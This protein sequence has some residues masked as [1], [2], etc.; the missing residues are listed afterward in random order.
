MRTRAEL[1]AGASV[2]TAAITFPANTAGKW[3]LSNGLTIIVQEDR[4]APVASVQ[5]WCG[6]GSIDEDEHLGA[7][8]SH[9]LEH[10]LFKGTKKR[11]ANQIA[12]AVQDVG[13]YINAY[14]SFD[15]TV[16]WIDVPKDGVSVALDVLSDAMMNSTL[17]PSE[18]AKE[19]EVI[20]REFA[21]GEDDPDRMV[22][23][24]LFATAF[25][26]HPYRLPVIG[27]MDIYNQL[28]QEQVMQYYKKRYVPNN[29]TF[30]V[31]GDVTANAV[32]DQ[33]AAFFEK[34][35]EKSLKPLF[36]PREPPQL[37]RRELHQEFTTP[38][39]R[40]AMAWH[41]PEVTHADVPALDLLSTILGD[42]RSSRLYRRAREETG[43]AFGISSFCYTPGDPGIFG[44]DATLEASN[45][46]ALE[47]LILKVISDVQESGVI[48]AE[49]AKSKKTL[50]THHLGQLTTMRGQASDIGTN[51]SLTQN[52][53]FSREY[54]AAIQ[55]V[56]LDD[57][58]RVAS[59][60]LADH[61]LTIVSLNPKGSVESNAD[62]SKTITPREIQKI[63][64]ANG[65]RILVREDPRLPLVSITAIFRSGLLAETPDT[66]GITR[67]LAK[68]MVKGTT[69][70]SAEEIA[71]QIEALGGD[72]DSGGRDNSFRITLDVT[73]PDLEFGCEI[74]ADILLNATF[75]EEQLAREKE[76]QL[77]SIREED[78]RPAN[79][80]RN[81]LRKTMFEDHPYA[82]RRR[83]SLDSVASLTR[84]DVVAF[85]DQYVVARN[86]VLSVFGN[87]TAPEVQELFERL[88]GKMKPGDL[89]H[90]NA[91]PPREISKPV[92]TEAIR[93]KA[94]AIIVIGYRGEDIFSADR[95][96]LELIDEASSDIGS[97]FF[98]RI[99]E[100]M[101]LAYYVGAVHLQGLV[102]GFFG[103]YV[104][105]D[106]QKL[107]AVKQA[108]LEEIAALWTIGMSPE[109]LLRA[110]KKIV[111]QQQIANQSNETFGYMTALDELYGLGFDNY[112]T[113]ERDIE[114]IS[115]E[116]IKR[117]AGKF[118]RDQP[119]VIAIVRPP[120][121]LPATKEK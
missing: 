17:P 12:Q 36:I 121:A 75:P 92:T 93:E 53:N 118:F 70:R 111:G 65:L 19:Q 100:E 30:V 55:R 20:R 69:T 101:G 73:R 104:G 44:V 119:P 59:H 4:S 103:F 60:Y 74:L 57:I 89:A 96:V 86:G 77:A 41:V 38:L 45:R 29:L 9:I 2:D 63:T 113:L 120:L 82:L 21:M 23:Q 95:H 33:L 108:M 18:Y 78:D 112:K 42:G 110:K 49:L 37:G 54:L 109:E 8:L 88:L 6:T 14:T 1:N 83:G 25:T 31:V 16:Y 64:L 51:W 91:K 79:V 39:T 7:G 22:G 87:V 15:R 116:D 24:L 98:V 107:D 13:G 85:R 28:T 58:R 11:A 117:V 56:T 52:L 40:L 115:V 48:D 27:R 90:K 67:L 43:L 84:K 114:N 68:T 62:A 106:P 61:N 72:I 10:L 32:R 81:L 97:R 94:Q 66:N 99:R 46:G 47:K 26:R 5:V 105:T 80:A 3:V 102:P 50:L 34:H 35:P 71:E 76:I